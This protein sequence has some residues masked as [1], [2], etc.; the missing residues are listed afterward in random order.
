MDIEVPDKCPVCKKVS[1]NL[2]LHIRKKDEC[3]SGTDPK[4]LNDWREAAQKIRRRK[5]QS[6]YI[7]SGKHKEVQAKYIKKCEEEDKESVLQIQR[8]KHA[9]FYQRRFFSQKKRRRSFKQLCIRML[10]CLRRGECPPEKVLNKFHIVEDEKYSR[11]LD[12]NGKEYDPEK[13]HKWV[14][15]VNANLLLSVI[16]LQ[17]VALVPRSTWL[18]AQLE[19]EN[20]KNEDL[21][22]KFYKL[23][24]KLQAYQHKN[25]KDVLVPEKY[26]SSYKLRTFL[27]IS[28][29]SSRSHYSKSYFD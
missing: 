23:I 11:Y 21:K 2:L 14:K 19:V 5:A 20:C 28:L 27:A 6:K 12:K 3:S 22:A 15:D 10:H 16:T 29:C 25:T 13:L 9:R 26:K 8:H 1:K 18:K 17:K 4:L 7:K 24:G